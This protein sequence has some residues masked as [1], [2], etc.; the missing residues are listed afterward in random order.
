MR[1]LMAVVFMCVCFS[2]SAWAQ[3]ECEH[4]C[5]FKKVV[6][7]IV[8]MGEAWQVV[9]AGKD[10]VEIRVYPDKDKT[11]FLL[12]RI[13]FGGGGN[14]VKEATNNCVWAADRTQSYQVLKWS[15]SDVVVFFL[16]YAPW[17]S[18]DYE[19]L[20]E[21]KDDGPF[22][23]LLGWSR[24]DE[25]LYPGKAWR[26]SKCDQPTEVRNVPPDPVLSKPEERQCD[27][28]RWQK[29][30]RDKYFHLKGSAYSV[31]PPMLQDGF[32]F[33]FVSEGGM[34]LTE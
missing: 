19:I 26:F 9:P 21:E 6:Q 18:E 1:N 29:R 5:V 22:V 30:L 17:P 20:W 11:E 3:A 23:R 32:R 8:P 24:G 7:V 2:S 14:L 27:C 10:S 25:L 13:T 16:R 34:L 12:K 4:Q 31:L 28:K 15:F 33:E